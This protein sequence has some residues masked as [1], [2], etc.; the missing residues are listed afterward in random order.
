MFLYSGAISSVNAVVAAFVS[1]ICIFTDNL[2]PVLSR[3][4]S[5]DVEF[6]SCYRHLIAIEIRRKFAV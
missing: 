3:R 1:D 2:F 6:D 5:K 4:A